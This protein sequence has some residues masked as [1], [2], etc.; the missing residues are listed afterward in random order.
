MGAPFAVELFRGHPRDLR[1]VDSLFCATFELRDVSSKINPT[2][3]YLRGSVWKEF[4][5]I[6][7][8]LLETLS[9]WYVKCPSHK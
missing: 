7:L 5:T 8:N 9:D 1:N 4:E 3:E 2:A 6:L